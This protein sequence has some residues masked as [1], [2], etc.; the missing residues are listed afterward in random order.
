MIDHASLAVH[1][2]AASRAFYEQALEP[3]GYTVL[4]VFGDVCGMGVAKPQGAG[5]DLWLVPSQNPTT[6]PGS[7]TPQW[8]DSDLEL[9]LSVPPFPH[10]LIGNSISIYLLGLL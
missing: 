6:H 10:L 2:P 9:T 1:D 3:L 8:C 4:M 7:A 5:P